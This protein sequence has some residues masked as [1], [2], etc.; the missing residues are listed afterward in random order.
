MNDGVIKRRR[1]KLARA[2][3]PK[4]GE[5]FEG[6]DKGTQSTHLMGS[7]IIGNDSGRYHVWPTITNK[8]ETGEYRDQSPDE[9]FKA[10]EVF[11]FR[12][13]KK[14]KKFE[15]GSWKKGKARKEAMRS[16]RQRKRNG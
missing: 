16:Y 2:M 13:K 15:A 5:H 4:K 7:D 14:A 8:T 12:S 1:K 11:E 10:G 9:A 6:Q 3:R